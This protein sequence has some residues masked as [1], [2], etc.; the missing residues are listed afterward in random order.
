MSESSHDVGLAQ[1]L[2][3]RLN[4]QVLPRA[5]ELKA[6]VDRGEPLDQYDT[7]FLEGELAEATHILPL[8]N[9]HP[10][11]QHLFG[12]VM[13]LCKEIMDKAMEN[14]KKV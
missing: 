9:Q 5:L 13:N 6:K 10:E 3:E 12:G 11:Y 8:I 1:V 7:D 14:A 4:T 2:L